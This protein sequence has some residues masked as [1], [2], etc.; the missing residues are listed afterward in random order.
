MLLSNEPGLGPL[1]GWMILAL[2]AVLL[3]YPPYF[4]GL[5]FPR[6]MLTTQLY[7]GFILILVCA[8]KLV[9][10]DFTFLRDPL[11]WAVFAYVISYI[12]S[13]AFPYDFREALGGLMKVIT[14]F[15]VYWMLRQMVTE[16]KWIRHCLTALF[17]SACM[18]AVVG[19]GVAAGLWKYDGSFLN[20][21]IQS[22]LQYANSTSTYMA[23]MAFIGV[24]LSIT[25]RNGWARFAYVTLSSLLILVSLSCASKGAWVVFLAGLVLFLIGMP[26]MFRLRSVYF[27]IA[28]LVTAV[29]TTDQFLPNVN[30]SAP[31]HTIALL[32]LL[33]LPAL[34]AGW[35]LGWEGLSRAAK[36]IGQGRLVA[37]AL[38]VLL[39]T[40]GAFFA[41][42]PG[43]I[44]YI[45]PKSVSNE[46]GQLLQMRDF[47]NLPF[48][49]AA[50]VLT[51]LEM[52]NDALRI[53]ADHP[54]GIGSGGWNLA[55]HEYQRYQYYST[56]V[57]N[58]F[59]Q[60]GIEA[61]FLGLLSI[62]ACY[63][64]VLLYAWKLIRRRPLSEE[65]QSDQVLLWGMITTIL[66]FS[67]HASFD[68][69]FSIP[70][71]QMV[72]FALI[73]LVGAQYRIEAEPDTVPQP[74]HKW[75]LIGLIAGAS[76]FA[77]VSGT[78]LAAFNANTLGAQQQQNQQIQEASKRFDKAVQ[79]DPGKAE[80]RVNL[81]R[82]LAQMASATNLDQQTSNN[83][84]LAAIGQLK[85]AYQSSPHNFRYTVYSMQVAQSIGDLD[86]GFFFAQ[87]A[88]RQNPWALDT[89]HYLAAMHLRTATR[90]ANQGQMDQAAA[91]I[92]SAFDIPK[93]IARQAA[94]I[95]EDRK[96]FWE[97]APLK[98][99]PTTDMILAQGYYAIGDYDTAYD[100]LEK[101]R[102]D[103]VSGN[104]EYQVA[105]AAT[106]TKLGHADAAQPIVERLKSVNPAW[107]QQYQSLLNQPV[108]PYKK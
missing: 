56:E 95:P 64:L 76:V 104:P 65:S 2:L 78:Y 68:F 69:D 36:R 80:Y 48:H 92:R 10:R 24:A 45:I 17:A 105:Y 32:S 9:R 34:M 61:G 101:G 4:Q 75:T 89:Y 96:K 20:G 23:V 51:R 28:T 55:Y 22:T 81:G 58:F 70:A 7:S 29:V 47:S 3:F 33:I 14:Y 15:M 82:A 19:I 88:Q 59:L 35:T 42:V 5:F 1:F 98:V 37:S 50:S 13:L 91:S 25:A 43:G 94:K 62:L 54:L 86:T 53:M 12:I 72:L 85:E 52:Y 71:L 40:T 38:V 26:G 87:A 49:T 106:I 107:E 60:V 84:A 21:A 73:G 99:N 90:S 57:H 27:L 100:L 63:V 6:A 11:D 97:N 8:Y 103:P 46:M 18:V 74:V 66:A 83:L 41:F 44:N 93:R 79:L 39:L 16:K 30:S 31:N 108:I 77:F 102:K 67:L